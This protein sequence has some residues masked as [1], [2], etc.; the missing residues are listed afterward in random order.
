ML[1]QFALKPLE[2]RKCVGGCAGKATNDGS[3]MQLTDLLGIG[4]HDRLAHGDLAITSDDDFAVFA[5]RQYGGAVPSGRISVRMIFH[6]LDMG[7]LTPKRKRGLRRFEYLSG[8]VPKRAHVGR[9]GP[10]C[11][12]AVPSQSDP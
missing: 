7:R 8:G 6:F 4:L 9:F 10:D 12:S 11:R 3:V 5:H 1:L 2:Q